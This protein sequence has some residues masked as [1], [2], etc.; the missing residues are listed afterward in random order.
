M[1][2]PMVVKQQ[3]VLSLN[4]NVDNESI[5]TPP[6]RVIYNDATLLAIEKP[7]GIVTHPAYRHP[8]GTVV[9]AIADWMTAMNQPRPWLVHR[10]DRDTSGIL[11]FSKTLAAQR[12]FTRQLQQHTI[13]K[14]YI[15]LVWGNDLP[16]DGM[17]T[18]ALRRDPEDRR[19]VIIDAAGQV[20]S[21]R[22]EVIVAWNDVS[23]LRLWP[24]T[25]RTHQL[26]VHMASLG[27]PIVG[28][29]VYA[30]SYPVADRL[31][32]HATAV[33][34]PMGNRRRIT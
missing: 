5:Q 22:F 4:C 30:P 27:H 12:Y 7:A 29:S 11:M 3:N 19:R 15:A 16:T 23:L 1:N 34:L 24:L 6:F 26:R 18:E 17:I 2:T 28:D 25:G 10:L 32:L 8:D 21:T 14:E 9:D 13:Q 31:L 33:T 20:A